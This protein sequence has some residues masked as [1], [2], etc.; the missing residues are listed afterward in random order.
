MQSRQSI[1]TPMPWVKQINL[2]ERF[3]SR[4]DP[5]NRKEGSA[6]DA[7][8]ITTGNAAAMHMP[9]NAEEKW[10]ASLQVTTSELNCKEA[11]GTSSLP[12][13][14]GEDQQLTTLLELAKEVHVRIRNKFY[15]AGNKSS[16]KRNDVK[17][18]EHA[19][20]E[21]VRRA[22]EE[23]RK[24]RELSNKLNKQE[25]FARVRQAKGHNCDD[26][27]FLACEFLR[28]LGCNAYLLGID[29]CHVCV[30]LLRDKVGSVVLPTQMAQLQNPGVILDLWTNDCCTTDVYET[31]YQAKMMKWAK[32]GKQ[33]RMNDGSWMCPTNPKWLDKIHGK[34]KIIV[35]LTR[36]L[37]GA[38]AEDQRHL[39]DLFKESMKCRMH[40]IE[41]QKYLAQICRA[42]PLVKDAAL[43]LDMA[44]FLKAEMAACVDDFPNLDTAEAP[45]RLQKYAK[46]LIDVA[47]LSLYAFGE[48]D[49]LGLLGKIL[50]ASSHIPDDKLAEKVGTV[51]AGQL[52]REEA[53]KENHIPERVLDAMAALNMGL[54][55]ECFRPLLNDVVKLSR[56]QKPDLKKIDKDLKLVCELMKHIDI[57]QAG[58]VASAIRL[59]A[60]TML[61][62]GEDPSDKSIKRIAAS[63]DH[64]SQYL[65]VDR[66]NSLHA[67]IKNNKVLHGAPSHVIGRLFKI[68]LGL[69]K[70]K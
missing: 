31:A 42:L 3:Q 43:R 48:N 45:Q 15:K 49:S 11:G 54:R 60:Y 44:V 36:E 25:R 21:R 37:E 67:E 23:M 33:I 40:E 10:R 12:T 4:S 70:S 30:L 26:L 8:K 62:I 28:Q 16:N 53:K 41:P 51:I 68:G 14:Q 38:A 20:A 27:S 63:V 17:R 69:P 22:S 9:G 19:E 29:D 56:E 24:T 46:R 50:T 52:I 34:K 39:F 59:L 13:G 2:S 65:D 6:S 58:E 55:A 35:H 5:D 64:L 32:E 61:R 47:F 7:G 1:T 66:W 18:G 57:D